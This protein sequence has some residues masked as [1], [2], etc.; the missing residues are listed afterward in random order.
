MGSP[1]D[2]RASIA[3][4]TGSGLLGT[5]WASCRAGFVA[6][7][8][9]LLAA[10]AV[11][12]PPD[13]TEQVRAPWVLSGEADNRLDLSV[14]TAGADCERYSGVDVSESEDIV[15]IRAWVEVPRQDG[16]YLVRGYHAVTV[17]LGSPLGAR[18]LT[19]CIIE[20]S[21]PHDTRASCAEVVET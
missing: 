5:R 6:L 15:E 10:C 19:G 7:G 9:L 14:M 18:T 16:C 4:R 8:F 2:T 13:R 20:E 17:T 21:L 3:R 1:T 12:P 11:S